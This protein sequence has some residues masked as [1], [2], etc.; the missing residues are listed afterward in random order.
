VRR[1][2]RYLLPLLA[3][4]IAAACAAALATA[5]DG[6]GQRASS[7]Y[8]IGFW[9]D[10][11]YSQEQKETGVPNLIADMNRQRLAFSVHDGDIKS[12]SSRCDDEVYAQAET[13]FNSLEAPAMYTP[14]DNEWTDCDRPSAGAYSSRE[15]LEHIRSTLFD[16]P[17]SS[18]GR[19]RLALEHQAAPY[20]ENARWQVDRV[21]YATLHVVGSDNNLGDEAPDPVEFEARDRAT[22]QWL[23]ETF[24]QAREAE[25]AAVLL[26]A[27][28]NPG[29]DQ[30]DPTRA[31]LRDPRTLAPQDGFTNFLRALREE[32]IAFRRPVV[33]V[34]G[35]S[36]YFRVDKP[37]LDTAGR[38]LENFTRVET[39]GDNAQAGNNDVQWTKVLVDPRSR[40]VFSFQPQIV[41]GNRVAVPSADGR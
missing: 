23:R 11:P 39:P 37:L 16:T 25:A 32:T 38:R 4:L 31:P 33:L 26:V 19:R 5:A 21:T 15:R 14:G 2:R 27:Q 20:V 17:S 18:F 40:E 6:D 41:P 8:A 3:A 10:V 36:H 7:P 34:H 1:M 35:D 22:N 9:G 30:S 24:A 12:G 13:Y 29:F 28:A